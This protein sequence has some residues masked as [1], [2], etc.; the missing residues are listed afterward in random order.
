MTTKTI[1]DGVG[2]VAPSQVLKLSF[3]MSRVLIESFTNSGDGISFLDQML[4]SFSVLAE[5]FLPL[6]SL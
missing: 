4:D 2:N 3:Q 5:K 1:P 6:F